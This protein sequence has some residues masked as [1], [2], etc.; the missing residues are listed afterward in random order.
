MALFEHE[1]ECVWPY[2]IC[3]VLAVIVLTISIWIGAY[4]AYKCMNHVKKKL[5]LKKVL[6]IKQH[7]LIKLINGQVKEINIKNRTYYFFTWLIYDMIF[8]TMD[9]SQL[10]K[11]MIMKI[12]TV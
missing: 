1:T 6:I 11:S 5:L 7:F 12:F 4:C 3:V 8:I 10:K 9:T 2:T